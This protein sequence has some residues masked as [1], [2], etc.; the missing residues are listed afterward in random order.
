MLFAHLTK[1]KREIELLCRC[2]EIIDFIAL[3]CA[4]KKDKKIW[5]SPQDRS[6]N[7]TCLT[8]ECSKRIEDLETKLIKFGDMGNV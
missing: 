5:E 7:Y 8:F 2:S 6:Q 4:K 3:W 1:H